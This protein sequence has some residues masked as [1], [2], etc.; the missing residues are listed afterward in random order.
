MNRNLIIVITVYS[1]TISAIILYFLTLLL[2]YGYKSLI[3]KDPL[4]K[5]INGFT[6]WEI[7]HLLL[8]IVLG[9]LIPDWFIQLTL[10]GIGWEI[11]EVLL[12]KLSTPTKNK[13]TGKTTNWWTGSFRDIIFNTL[14]FAIGFLLNKQLQK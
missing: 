13:I 8:Y 9:Y 4:N 11:V 7:S 3:D 12:G 2:M 14:G 5:N 1:I 6:L 10:V